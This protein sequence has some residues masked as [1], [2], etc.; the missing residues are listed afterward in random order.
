MTKRRRN[1][2]KY[3]ALG[4]FVYIFSLLVML[5]VFWLLMTNSDFERWSTQQF[6]LNSAIL[7]AVIIATVAGLIPSLLTLWWV[8]RNRAQPDE[9]FIFEETPTRQAASH[10]FEQ[11]VA[12]LIKTLTGNQTVVVGG[13]GDGGVDIEVYNEK[14]RLIGVIQCKQ[15]KANKILPPAVIRELNTVKHYRQ[16]NT[17]YLVTTGRFSQESI[18]LARE[19]GVRL[20]SG[21]ELTKL[22]QKTTSKTQSPA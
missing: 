17:A 21:T 8:R 15:V 22:R 14:Q 4:Q 20:I 13:A 18:E 9:T 16:V 19:L 10:V 2:A 3:R 6:G 11:E 1:S 12:A 5:G 7:V